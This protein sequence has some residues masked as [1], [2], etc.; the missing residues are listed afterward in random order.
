MPA[1]PG[2]STRLDAPRLR[3][4]AGLFDERAG[5]PPARVA[6]EV[7]EETE[8]AVRVRRALVV[9][10]VDEHR[11]TDDGVARDVAPEATVEAVVAVVAHHEVVAFGDDE[12]L[13]AFVETARTAQRPWVPVDDV[14]ELARTHG[15]VLP[16][17]RLALLFLARR[18]LL[19]AVQRV[20][21]VF[22]R[23]VDRR[24][25]LLLQQLA[26]DVNV[27]ALRRDVVARQADDALHVVRLVRD[28]VRVCVVDARLV[29]ETRLALKLA[30][31]LEDDHVAAPY[32][33]LRQER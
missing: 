9:R 10:P 25:L 7:E 8:R 1:P 33:A 12:L 16:D 20:A 15:R 30:W 21:V 24:D 27:R 14:R 22:G 26:V 18:A 4:V 5:A 11:A 31:V 23:R 17:E 2:R 19:V 28:V 32:L 13:R 3:D 6:E 29:A